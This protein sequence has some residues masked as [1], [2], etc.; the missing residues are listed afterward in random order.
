MA[1]LLENQVATGA[2]AFFPGAQSQPSQDDD[3]DNGTSEEEEPEVV[4]IYFTKVYFFL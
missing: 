2:T 4:L 3:D 1:A